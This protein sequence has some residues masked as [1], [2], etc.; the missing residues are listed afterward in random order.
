MTYVKAVISESLGLFAF[1]AN[2]QFLTPIIRFDV[3]ILSALDLHLT[4][5]NGIFDI[6]NPGGFVFLV[7][8][9]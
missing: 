1:S 7:I 3:V 4:P 8:D 2:Q 9:G 6:L 5:L